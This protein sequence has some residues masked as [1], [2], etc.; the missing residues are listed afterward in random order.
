MNE[1]ELS[2][3]SAWLFWP[4]MKFN[5][6]FFLAEILQSSFTSIESVIDNTNLFHV[7]LFGWLNSRQQFF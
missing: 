7:G 3:L 4:D 5:F 6:L 2:L 1:V